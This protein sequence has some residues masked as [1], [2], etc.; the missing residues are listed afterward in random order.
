ML[1]PHAGFGMMS[2][3]DIGGR[4]GVRDVATAVL[5]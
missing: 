5:A 4:S 3:M 1:L 2:D